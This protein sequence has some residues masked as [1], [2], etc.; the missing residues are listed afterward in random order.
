MGWHGSGFDKRGLAQTLVPVD[1]SSQGSGRVQ[2]VSLDRP[3]NSLPLTLLLR[4][5]HTLST[6]HNE[7]QRFVETRQASDSTRYRS[8]DQ[9][10]MGS[11]DATKFSNELWQDFDRR[12]YSGISVAQST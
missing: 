3:K 8:L 7:R 2:L 4:D 5:N 11:L 1:P 6:T 10:R 12:A 9:S